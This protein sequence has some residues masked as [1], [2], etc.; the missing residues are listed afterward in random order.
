MHTLSEELIAKKDLVEG[1][2]EAW[3]KDLPN[4]WGLV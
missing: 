2:R 1:G 3:S 4:W